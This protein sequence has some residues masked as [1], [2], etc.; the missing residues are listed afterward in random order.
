MQRRDTLR[1]L[2]PLHRDGVVQQL[3][4]AI[5]RA[6][7]LNLAKP[8]FVKRNIGAAEARKRQFCTRE[9]RRPDGK[10]RVLVTRAQPINDEFAIWRGCAP[11]VVPPR[12]RQPPIG[13]AAARRHHHLPPPLARVLGAGGERRLQALERWVKPIGALRVEEERHVVAEEVVARVEKLAQ[14]VAH[15]ET[16]VESSGAVGLQRARVDRRETV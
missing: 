13:V 4:E 1:H 10:R 7:G 15:E 2:K 14:R 12:H 3:V 11:A 6:H 9:C 16:R 5:S 8:R